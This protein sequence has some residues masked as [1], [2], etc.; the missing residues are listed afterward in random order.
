MSSPNTSLSQSMDHINNMW[1][2]PNLHYQGTNRLSEALNIVGY[3]PTFPNNT[4]DSTDFYKLDE[5]GGFCQGPFTTREQHE[6]KRTLQSGL[7]QENTIANAYVIMYAANYYV[8]GFSLTTTCT[9]TNLSTGTGTTCDRNTVGTMNSLSVGD[10][11]TGTEPFV[12]YD[13]SYGGDNY[14]Y[15]GYA[16]YN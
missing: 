1:Y 5:L 8:R 16:G 10:I 11:I 3:K 6:C 9:V 15:G 4:Y 7:G 12:I 13:T 14:A 2:D